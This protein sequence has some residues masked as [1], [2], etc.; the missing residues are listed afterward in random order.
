MNRGEELK[1]GYK[2]T[3]L[4]SIR[5]NRSRKYTS[6]LKTEAKPGD[7]YYVTIPDLSE[8]ECII[9]DTMCLSY[10]FVNSNAKSWFLNNLGKLLCERLT[11]NICGEV[12]YDNTGESIL[13]IYKDLWKSEKERKNMSEY[14]LAN[15]NVRKLMS[16]DDSGSKTAKTDGV[17]DLTISNIYNRLKT[18]L[19]KI[20]CDHGSYAPYGMSK[21]Q[22]RITL[23]QPDKIM[24][25]QTNQKVDGY[26][27]D[28]IQFEYETIESESLAKDVREQ[29]QVGRSLS[30]DYTTLL[31]TLS[32]SKSSTKEVIS[33]SIPRK[34]TKAVVLLFNK[35]DAGDSE[36]FP[37]P[38][39]TKVKVTVKGKSN[40]VYDGGLRAS[41]MYNEAKRFFGT[42]N[43]DNDV[44]ERDYYTKKFAMVIDFRTVDDETVVGSGRRLTGKSGVLIEMEKKSTATDLS[45]HVFVI[46][47]GLVNI[48][49]NKLQGVEY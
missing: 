18:P 34:S 26:K 6:V 5:G 49:E 39:I 32:W 16:K 21:F 35:D 28:N 48:V 1:P 3:T 43:T 38:E 46:A 33:I 17:L 8:N 11:V 9:P 20:L 47:D 12:V 19:G 45:C 24:K 14:G 36:D 25:A 44:S 4:S 15:E 40:A 42:N 2:K 37:Y 23:S 27:L 10:N 7:T 31:E 22:Y 41:E 29:Y 13:E 30:Y